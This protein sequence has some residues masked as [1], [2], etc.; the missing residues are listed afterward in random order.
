MV[1]YIFPQTHSAVTLLKPKGSLILKRDDQ[2][3][4][5]TCSNKGVNN[6]VAIPTRKIVL[7]IAL[8]SIATISRSKFRARAICQ[9]YVAL[10]D[11]YISD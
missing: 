11:R 4:R 2:I 10:K 1:Q 3:T 7:L 5:V 6:N 9:V 8:R